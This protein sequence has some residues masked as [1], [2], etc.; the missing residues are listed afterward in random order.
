MHR[1]PIY[2]HTSTHTNGYILQKWIHTAK[3]DTYFKSTHTNGTMQKANAIGTHS[4][5]P[6]N[7]PDTRSTYTQKWIH[8]KAH[9]QIEDNQEIH[10]H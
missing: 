10:T 1:D 4:N 5:P 8:T 7:T 6:T 2:T 9:S 3:M